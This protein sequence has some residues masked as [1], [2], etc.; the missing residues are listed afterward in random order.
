[1][2]N[3]VY[4]FKSDLKNCLLEFSHNVSEKE[5]RKLEK[6]LNLSDFAISNLLTGKFKLQGFHKFRCMYFLE[7]HGYLCKE[8]EILP[9]EVY[10]LGKIIS[11]NIIS[12]E[13]SAANLDYNS[14]EALLKVF[15]DND[16]INLD[17]LDNY[18]RNFTTEHLSLKHS[19]NGEE[20]I[21]HLY[22]QKV[23]PLRHQAAL[24]IFKHQVLSILPITEYLLSDKFSDE[25]R[26][27]LLKAIPNNGLF[28]LSYALQA[29]CYKEKKD[30]ILATGLFNKK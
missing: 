2:K 22:D 14:G 9:T 19:E 4:T 6:H 18:L 1:M 25:E 27:K 7:S 11:N 15:E 16:H 21:P 26:D 24:E 8:L 29:L 30:S 10:V 5:I 23:D 20:F 12:L 13:V 3:N 17:K 28:T